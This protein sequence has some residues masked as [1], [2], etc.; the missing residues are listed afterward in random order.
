MPREQNTKNG[1]L[2]NHHYLQLDKNEYD[3]LDMVTSRF[4]N[5][6]VLL[7]TLTSF[8]L[9][10]I[11]EYNN[12]DGYNKRI[13]AV[14][15]I[16]GPGISGAEAIGSERRRDAVGQN[17]RYFPQRFLERPYLAELRR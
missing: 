4:D 8:Q 9:D 7:N 14:M 1:G 5:V 2:E 12:T 10:F 16:G 15:W 17:Y 13:D 3:M 11:A 6:I